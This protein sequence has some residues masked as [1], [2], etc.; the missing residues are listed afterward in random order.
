MA[1]VGWCVCFWIGKS[2][3][4]NGCWHWLGNSTSQFSVKCET[5]RELPK[6]WP[7]AICKLQRQGMSQKDIDLGESAA[8]L[9][10]SAPI[11][12][13]IEQKPLVL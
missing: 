12:A 4:L 13:H 7:T 9:L 1:G 5:E 10:L 3:Y 2:A 11:V 8:P 6:L